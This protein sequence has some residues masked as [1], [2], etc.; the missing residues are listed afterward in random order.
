MIGFMVYCAGLV[1]GIVGASWMVEM[2]ENSKKDSRQKRVT[3]DDIRE[4]GRL[5]DTEK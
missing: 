1:G 4:L 5:F 3:A 2:I